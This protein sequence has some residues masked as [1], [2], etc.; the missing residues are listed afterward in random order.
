[1]RRRLRAHEQRALNQAIAEVD[2]EAEPY[3]EA[4]RGLG[5]RVAEVLPPDAHDEAI[6]AWVNRVLRVKLGSEL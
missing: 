1:M 4:L 2:L 3:L 5:E 6:R